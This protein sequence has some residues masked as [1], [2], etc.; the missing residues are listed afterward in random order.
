[1]PLPFRANLARAVLIGA[2][3]EIG[4]PLPEGWSRPTQQPF[5]DSAKLGAKLARQTAM[6]KSVLDC[7]LPE[8]HKLFQNQ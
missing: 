8:F 7:L 1:M 6:P 3:D 2:I 4:C 5:T